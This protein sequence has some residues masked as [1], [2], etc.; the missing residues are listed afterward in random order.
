MWGIF[1][2]RYNPTVLEA[3]F[4]NGPFHLAKHYGETPIVHTSSFLLPHSSLLNSILFFGLIFSIY[5]I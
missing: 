4:G 1:F 5:L 2:A 3:L